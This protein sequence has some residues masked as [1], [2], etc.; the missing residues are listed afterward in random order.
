MWFS[1]LKQ[2]SIDF[3][4]DGRVSWVE[5]EDIPLKLWSENTCKHIA[6]KWGVLLDVDDPEE[7]CFYR[8]RVCINTSKSSNVFE[9]FKLIYQGKLI[10]DNLKVDKDLEGDDEKNE[11][12]ETVFKEDLP[13]SYGGEKYVG[14]NVMQS[15]DPFNIYPLLNKKKEGNKEVLSTNDSLKYPNGFTPREDV[16]TNVEMSKQRNTSGREAGDMKFG[17]NNISSKEVGTESVCSSHFK[18]SET[19]RSCGSIILLMDELVSYGKLILIISVYAAQE[20]TEQKLFWDYLFHVIA[21]CKGEVIIMGDFNEVSN[22]NERFGSVFNVKGANAFNSFISNGGLEEVPLGG[23]SFTW[24][25]KSASKMSKLERFLKSESL[26]SSCPNILAIS[27]DRY[28]S[29]HRLI[30]IFGENEFL[31]HFK[32]WFKSPWEFCLNINMDFPCKLTSI[33]QSDLEIE[34]SN[35][36]IKSMI[37]ECEVDKS[38]G[39]DGFTFGFYCHFWKLMEDD[40]VAAMKYFFQFGSI[41]KRCNSSF[42]TLI[43]KIRDAKMVTDFRPISLYKIIAKILADRLVV[44]LG[45]IVNEVDF[46][47]AY[48][49]VRWDYMDD[50]L[51]KFS[52]KDRV[53]D[54][55]MFK[56][57]MLDSSMQ[58]SYMFYDDDAIFVGKWSDSN[59]DTIV[60]VLDYCYRASG[61]RI[62]MS[63]SKLMG[64]A[65]DEHRVDQAASKIRCA[66]LKAPFSYLELSY[67]NGYD[68][69]QLI[70]YRYGQGSS[71]IFMVMMGILVRTRKVVICLY[72]V[73]LFRRWRL[74]RCKY[75]RLY[76][77]ELDKS[78]D[79]ATKLAHSSLVFS[80]CRDPRSGV[81]QSQMADLL[82][83]IEGISL[84]SMKDRWTWS[85]EGSGDFFVASV[86]K[87]VDDRRLP[88]V[89][90]KTR[91]IKAVHIKVNVHAWKVRLEGVPTRLNISCRGMDIDSIL[92]PIYGNV[93]ESSRH[94]FF[95]CHVVKELMYEKTI[96]GWMKEQQ[97]QVEKMAQQQDATFQAQLEELRAELQ[98]SLGQFQGRPEGNGDQGSLLPRSMC[99]DVPKITTEDP[100]KW[101]FAITKYFSL[102]NT[103]M[104]KRLWIV[105]FN[106]EGAAA[107]W[108][109][110]I[111][112]P[113]TLGDVFL[114]ARTIKARLD[115]QAALVA[116]TMAKTFGNHGGDESES[117]GLEFISQTDEFI[118]I[119]GQILGKTSLVHMDD[120]CIDLDQ[121]GSVRLIDVAINSD[122][123]DFGSKVPDSGSLGVTNPHNSLLLFVLRSRAVVDSCFGSRIQL[124][125]YLRS[126]V[127]DETSGV[128]KKRDIMTSGLESKGNNKI[129]E[130]LLMLLE[131]LDM[132]NTLENSTGNITNAPKQPTVSNVFHTY[133]SPGPVYYPPHAH[134]LG[135][136]GPSMA[137]QFVRDNNCTIEFD[138]YGFSVKDFMTRWV[139][140]QCDSTRDLYPVTAPSSIPHAFLVSQYVA[141]TSWTSNG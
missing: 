50:V 35:E 16:E 121:H 14:Q 88:D 86:R 92:C 25:H 82:S 122:V 4:I 65:V 20:L 136:F 100:E 52:F 84:V 69:S 37:W 139:L 104:E 61:L 141:S 123:A 66:I 119:E 47:K 12:P 75:P 32:N 24:C 93:V 133:A 131:R 129:D 115:D 34:V 97:D 80:F 36:E 5:L 78:I 31:T 22:K 127:H 83:K 17:L 120:F 91:W 103:P 74:S 135:P 134:F 55:G 126:L 105:G 76:A 9:S 81:K 19:P 48:D 107:E 138:A 87:L 111:S 1:Q 18:K 3:N 68:G 102:L 56:G 101:L 43:S 64:I 72:G 124:S 70:S 132:V 137:S 77:L 27:L 128:E 59:I 63:K 94:L 89:S 44:V 73:T 96:W 6:S 60:H 39:P 51:K 54:A 45:D 114:L 110:W 42:I 98:A 53:V 62:N 49:S 116:C 125:L 46:K 117:S 10:E 23:C 2:A 113:T 106:L 90:Y 58:L 85:F 38:P 7:N 130:L 108:F 118:I 28:L 26:L 71:R 15:E 40:V 99:L 67:L 140:L 13:K 57:F 8:K 29:D 79:V 30:L 112:R 41:P 11:V 109:R 33:Q 95:D 21:S